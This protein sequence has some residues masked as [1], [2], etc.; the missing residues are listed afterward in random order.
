MTQNES[1]SNLY[2]QK[3]YLDWSD[4]EIKANREFLRKDKEL[5]WELAQIENG[6]PNWREQMDAAAGAAEDAGGAPGAPPPMGGPPP[7]D[8]PPAFGGPADPGL[9]AGIEPP[10]AA[11]PEPPLA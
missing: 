3:K 10:P 4:A 1:I 5:N 8:G 6:G 2:A 9:D 11:D 7:M